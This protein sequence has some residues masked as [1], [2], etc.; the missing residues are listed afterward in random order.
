MNKIFLLLFLLLNTSQVLSKDLQ[1]PT[2]VTHEKVMID[3]MTNQ[4]NDDTNYI[5]DFIETILP[6][7]SNKYPK[8][9]TFV[10][11]YLKAL[12][13]NRSYEDVVDMIDFS[14]ISKSIK[15]TLRKLPKDMH[16]KLNINTDELESYK[17][18]LLK[19]SKNLA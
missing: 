13:K 5:M 12:T 7:I 14:K 2:L 9:I 18:M 19:L 16:E 8:A 4:V 6:L 15:N 1:K 11:S 10:A 3:S 17:S